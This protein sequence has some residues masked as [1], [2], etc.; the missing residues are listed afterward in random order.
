M[1]EE[2]LHLLD[3]HPLIDCSRSQSASEFVR[4]N[5]AHACCPSQ[6]S[7]PRLNIAN[8]HSLGLASQRNEE[9]RAVVMTLR[10]I[11]VDAQ[12]GT[13]VEVDWTLLVTLTYDDAFPR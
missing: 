10:E 12:L 11:L 1:A 3:R 2:L 5:T 13:G 8:G 4:V 6:F 7:H 9:R